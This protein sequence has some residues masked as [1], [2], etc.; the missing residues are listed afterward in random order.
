MIDDVKVDVSTSRRPPWTSPFLTARMVRVAVWTGAIALAIGTFLLVTHETIAEKE[1][2]TFD[3]TILVALAR[4]RTPRLT[5]IMVDLTALG[6]PTLVTLFTAVTFAILVVLR[7]RRGALHLTLASIGTWI[8]TSATKHII[9]RARPT[10]VERLV[11]VSGYSY[12]SGHSLAA[13]ALYLTM[14]IVAGTHLRTVSS[15][16]VLMAGA[17]ALVALVALSRV[18]LGVHYPSDVISGVSLG[19]AWA[20][21]LAAAIAV[22]TGRRASKR[23]PSPGG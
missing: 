2:A 23:A 1:G 9:E 10:E 22:V 8:W 6:S 13:A 5:G 15:K 20:L 11:E 7:D 16:A 3:R 4:L 19:T 17:S 21:I 14:A 18:Y 12:P